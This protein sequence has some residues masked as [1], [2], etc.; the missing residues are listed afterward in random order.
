[1][2]DAEIIYMKVNMNAR[3]LIT[4]E[5]TVYHK[6]IKSEIIIRRTTAFPISQHLSGQQLSVVSRLW[7]LKIK[8]VCQSVKTLPCSILDYAS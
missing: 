5:A 4:C 8:I 1:M 7:Y 6:S 3:V 2:T